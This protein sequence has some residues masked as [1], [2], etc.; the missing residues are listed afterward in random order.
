MGRFCRLVY[1]FLDNQRV[2]SFMDDD[3]PF[4]SEAQERLAALLRKTFDVVPFASDEACNE[5]FLCLAQFC[6]NALQKRNLRKEA[7]FASLDIESLIGLSRSIV[8]VDAGATS[9]KL[10]AMKRDRQP[11]SEGDER[12]HSSAPSRGPGEPAERWTFENAYNIVAIVE[13]KSAP[14]QLVV[15]AKPP[16]AGNKAPRT[17][18]MEA[19]DLRAIDGFRGKPAKRLK[20]N[21]VLALEEYFDETHLDFSELLG[22]IRLCEWAT[23]LV[24]HVDRKKMAK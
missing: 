2:W 18:C 16:V 20:T 17:F 21:L 9:E 3:P 12:E 23:D 10:L 7:K 22:T 15:K 11:G 13:L 1:F 24:K 6:R 5:L 19:D 8:V 4:C 14:L